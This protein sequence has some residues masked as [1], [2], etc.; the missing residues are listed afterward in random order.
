MQSKSVKIVLALSLLGVAAGASA[1]TYNGECTTRPQSEW[2]S[3]SDIS[4]RFTAQGYT[5]R[6]VKSKG[7][8]YEVYAVDKNGE[9]VELFVNP[10]TAA[11]VGQAGKP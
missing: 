6:K 5:V 10:A 3:T 7:S 2:K 1:S 4:A 9:K 11:V 8:C